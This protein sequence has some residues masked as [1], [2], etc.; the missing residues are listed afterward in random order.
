LGKP[1]LAM[2]QKWDERERW[3]WWGCSGL[4]GILFVFRRK[5]VQY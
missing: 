5:R 2:T 1:G 4:S 3:W